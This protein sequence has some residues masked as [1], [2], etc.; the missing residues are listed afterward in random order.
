MLYIYLCG[1]LCKRIR[2]T[3]ELAFQVMVD[4]QQR[5]AD[6][7][8]QAEPIC[9]GEFLTNYFIRMV[10]FILANGALRLIPVSM[11]S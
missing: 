5:F 7:Y 1:Q 9:V 4:R 11:I 10:N 2:N 8:I 6:L 3:F